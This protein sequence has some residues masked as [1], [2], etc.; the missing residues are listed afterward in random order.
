MLVNLTKLLEIDVR[1]SLI[2]FKIVCMFV[3]HV[4]GLFVTNHCIF[5]KYQLLCLP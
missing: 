3:L 2:V 1:Y 5:V 4:M